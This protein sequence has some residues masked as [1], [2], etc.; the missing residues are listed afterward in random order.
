MTR[1]ADALLPVP[2]PAINDL[3]TVTVSPGA[4]PDPAVAVSA[5]ITL[6]PSTLLL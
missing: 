3:S 5:L 6:T 4:Y 2:D 1:S